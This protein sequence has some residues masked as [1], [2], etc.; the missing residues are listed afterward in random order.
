MTIEK[1]VLAPTDSTYMTLELP[2][3][4]PSSTIAKSEEKSNNQVFNG[5]SR[6][7]KL[8]TKRH[9]DKLVSY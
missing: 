8:I 4:Y 2:L 9:K 7:V 6:P 3:I 1:I 5:Q